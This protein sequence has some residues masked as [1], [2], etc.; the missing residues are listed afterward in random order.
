MLRRAKAAARRS[1]S[2]G[3][4][5]SGFAPAEKERLA[6]AFARLSIA[7][8]AARFDGYGG[9]R[10]EVGE[11]LEQP[12]GRILV[13]NRLITAD[14]EAFA[15]DYLL[16]D[17]DG[18]WRILDVFL[19]GT[20]SE[21]ATKRSEYGGILKREGFIIY[22]GKLTVVDSFRIGHIGRMDAAVMHEVVAAAG[23]ALSE[24]CLLYTSPS[25][26]DS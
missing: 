10:F 16:A 3:R 12:R 25:P 5:W 20:V 7:T 15:I 17:F 22:P 14:G 18:R 26:R 13:R 8:F 24:I 11:A 6:A 23:A 21:I 2:A 1:F 4:H 19:D 9:E